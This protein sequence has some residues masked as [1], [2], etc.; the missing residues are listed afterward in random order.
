MHYLIVAGS[1][2]FKDYEY[3]KA[4]LDDLLIDLAK[5]N[6]PITIISGTANGADKLG[7]RYAKEKGYDIIR[8]PAD[9]EKKGKRAGYLRNAQMADKVKEEGF[10][11]C[12]CFWDGKS[13]GTNWMIK[14]CN[15]KQ[16]DCYIY[17]Y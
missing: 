8:M 10:G 5:N 6:Y 11:G 9:W 15:E 7:E 2:S 3:L 12:A 14:L 13:P 17:K 1:R 4:C 16:I